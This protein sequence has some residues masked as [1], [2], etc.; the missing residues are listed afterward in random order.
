MNKKRLLIGIIA[1]VVLL[2]V[3]GAIAYWNIG[4]SIYNQGVAAHNALDVYGA[5]ERYETVLQYYP[6]ALGSFVQMASENC[7]ACYAY[8]DARQTLDEGDYQV[9]CE[10]YEQFLTDFD[11]NRL[12]QLAIQD[13]PVAYLAWAQEAE[14]TEQY[15][16]AIEC[17]ETLIDL[18]PDS[19]QAQK[20]IQSIPVVHYDIGDQHRVAAEYQD[21]IDA[22]GLVIETGVE[23][24]WVDKAHIGIRET[25]LEWGNALYDSDEYETAILRYQDAIQENDDEQVA[26]DIEQKIGDVYLQWVADLF[27]QDDYQAAIDLGT[28]AI[29]DF[30]QAAWH[31]Q[32]HTLIQSTYLEWAESLQADDDYSA[33]IE[34]YQTLMA[35]YPDTESDAI[36]TQIIDIYNSWAENHWQAKEY[37]EASSV[38]Q[39]LLETYPQNALARQARAKLYQLDYDWAA[40]AY[41]A[42]DYETA[43]EHYQAG[44]AREEQVLLASGQVQPQVVSPKVY[45]VTVS[46]DSLN[47]RKGPSTEDAI[48]GVVK[49]DDELVVVGRSED[50]AWIQIE[51]PAGWVAAVL[52]QSTIDVLD[53]PLEVEPPLL[54]PAVV[55]ASASAAK[56]W[57]ATASAFYEWGVSLVEQ[58]EYEDGT[59]KFYTVV[60]EYPLTE[61]ITVTRHA[62]SQASL[63]WGD[64]LSDTEEYEAAVKVYETVFDIDVERTFVATAT[65]RIAGVYLAWGRSFQEEE[66]YNSAILK[67]A[68]IYTDYPTSVHVNAAY[69]GVISCY[70][71]WGDALLSEYKYSD[72]IEKYQLVITNFPSSQAAGTAAVSIGQ[73]YNAWGSVLHTQKKYV[74]AM[75]KFASALRAT[76]NEAVVSAAQKGYNDALWAIA[77][78]TDETGNKIINDALATAC[79]GQA[80]ASPAVNLAVDEAG[81]A[82]CNS[83]LVALPA[84]LKATMPAH[85][86]Y[87]VCAASGT[88][89]I[90]R[91]AYTSGYTLVRQQVWWKV[92][93]R[94]AKTGAW[95]AENT[96]YGPMPGSCPF[97]YMFY[98]KTA[99]K[100]G[101]SPSATDATNW[102]RGIIK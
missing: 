44:Y 79:Q 85:F 21:A 75:S 82:R 7:E 42:G 60:E 19:E 18:Y 4:L 13:H 33:A 28:S 91:C 94:N 63:D 15:L 49:R 51:E 16:T 73:V 58:G 90:Q 27:E 41:A 38:Y 39:E 37:Q 74:D 55:V 88:N 61:V 11:T 2:L 3:G 95:V 43:V 29:D 84:D 92:T 67:Y 99:Y 64:V 50:G 59:D 14:Q 68:V 46:T 24:E 1:I 87:A 5:I 69:A 97:S 86:R 31:D 98:S 81:K 83:N 45:T 100:S 30:P 101:G 12:V 72:A 22:Y 78:L 89:V 9:A 10:K 40:D 8:R 93:V 54:K 56:A 57:E 48:A 65:N 17:Y 36:H 32:M 20:A 62:A 52:V 25:Y 70:I 66:S 23:D 77:R 53:I 76:T 102:L 26:A 71:E 34:M 96:F 35:A 47:V 6:I 80:A